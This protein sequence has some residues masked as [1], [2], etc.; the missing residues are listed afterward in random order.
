MRIM[1]SQ[2]VLSCPG[3]SD[4]DSNK[5]LKQTE[6]FSCPILGTKMRYKN[7]KKYIV[8]YL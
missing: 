4:I 3:C 8:K 6:Y 2:F 5:S 1:N 7:A